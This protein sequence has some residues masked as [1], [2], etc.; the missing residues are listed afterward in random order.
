MRNQK[1][2]LSVVAFFLFATTALAQPTFNP[3]QD[4]KP[5]GKKWEKIENMSDEFN[6]TSLNT[7]KWDNQ[8]PQWKGR[9]PAYFSVNAVKVEGGNLKITAKKSLTSQEQQQNPGYFL[10]GGLVRSLNKA[11]YGYYETR[12]KANKTFMSSTFWL[13]NKRNEFT[14]C[15]ERTTELDVTENVGINSGDPNRN[16]VNE[17][18]V[19]INSNTHSR[20]VVGNPGCGITETFI[21]DKSP[22]GEPAYVNYHVYGVWWKNANEL[23]FFLDGQEVYRITPPADFDLGMYLRMVVE[24]Y[25]WN[26]PNTTLVNGKRQDGL[27]DTEANRTTFYDWTRSWR[28]VDDNNPVAQG[29]FGG[30]ARPIPGTIEAEDYDVGGQGVAYNDA[31]AVN[32]GPNVAREDEGVDIEARDGGQSVGWTADGEWLE[33]TVNATGGTYDLEARIATITTGKSIIAKLDGITLGTFNLPNTGD[34]GTFETVKIENVNVTGGNDKILRLEFVGG[35]TNLNWVKFSAVSP[36]GNTITIGNA[37]NTNAGVDGWNSNMVINESETYT[38]NT[39]ASQ[40]LNVDEFVFYANKEADPVTPF[41]VKVNGD[42]NFTVLA[43]GSSRTATAYNVGENTFSFN[44][45]TAKQ[46]TLANGETIAPGFLDANADGSGGSAG[47]VIAFDSNAPADQ[48]WYTGGAAS[49]N[50]GSVAEGA[51]PTAGLSTLTNLT[52]N[53]RFKIVLSVDTGSGGTNLVQNPGLETGDLSSWGGFGTL[54]IDTDANAGSYAVKVTG[55]AGHE[56]NVVVQPNTTYTLSAH[57]KVQSGSVILGVKNYG[58][59]EKGTSVTS[60]SYTPASV[61][62]TTGSTS[63]SADIYLYVPGAGNVAFGDDFSVVVGGSTAA[64]MAG[65]HTEPAVKSKLEKVRSALYPN[66][67]STGYFTLDL[68][69]YESDVSV[70]ILDAMGRLVYTTHTTKRS[71]NLHADIFP[72]KGLYIFN[73]NDQKVFETFRL[74]VK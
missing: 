9:K 11:T 59:A 41:V 57:A 33:Y 49:G 17:N 21:G 31:D 45:G 27:D 47:S 16:W 37:T 40:T 1:L 50:S 2:L 4:P 51:A 18:I 74:V 29:P 53:Y 66:P 42:N 22:I 5:A 54:A 71:L 64:R 69:G 55:I 19:S 36:P 61:T 10:Q 65:A 7:A 60:T 24:T 13:I 26:P 12:M 52:R 38:N 70:N 28:L 23:V 63:T 67:V 58:G 20:G 30:S 43:V 72:G 15:D 39:G 3:G 14:G 48:I 46:I 68:K 34:W 32:N 6:G 73:I 62:F 56:Q 44:T 35:G 8:S 25:D